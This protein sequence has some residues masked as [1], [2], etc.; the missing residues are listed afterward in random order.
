MADSSQE[1]SIDKNALIAIVILGAAALV[2]CG[3]ALHRTFGMR[4]SKGEWNKEFNQRN[5]EQDQY[6]VDL[7]MAYRNDVMADARRG[8]HHRPKHEGHRDMSQ[9]P[10]TPDSQQLPFSPAR[11]QQARMSSHTDSSY[12]G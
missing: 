10:H 2:L 9:L 8:Q 3:F 5:P 12:Y 4:V 11:P 6:M 1:M 7:R